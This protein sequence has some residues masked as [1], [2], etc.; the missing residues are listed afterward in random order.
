MRIPDKRYRINTALTFRGTGDASAT[1]Y[2]G[3]DHFGRYGR[4]ICGIQVK[5]WSK[6]FYCGW[7]HWWDFAHVLS[8]GHFPFPVCHGKD[9][10]RNEGFRPVREAWKQSE[11]LL[12]RVVLDEEFLHTKIN[13]KDVY[14]DYVCDYVVL[15]KISQKM[16]AVSGV[17]QCSIMEIWQHWTEV[18]G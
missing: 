10:E 5:L 4:K 16:H 12:L 17:R 3:L 7:L 2:F 14:M 1:R 9:S 8:T 6:K 15:Q 18:G 11:C 13:N